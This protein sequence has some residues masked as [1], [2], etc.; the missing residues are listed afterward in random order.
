MIS[1][2]NY[3]TSFIN[4]SEI[5]Y[6]D[7]PEVISLF[8]RHS[9]SVDRINH[10]RQFE[11]AL[12]KKWVTHDCYFRLTSTFIGQAVTDS[13]HLMV[14][15]RLFPLSVRKRFATI[16]GDDRSIPLK[17]YAGTLAAQLLHRADIV[18]EEERMDRRKRTILGSDVLSSDVETESIDDTSSH[19]EDV[20]GITF[21][22]ALGRRFE[23]CTKIRAFTDGNGSNHTIA[24]FPIIQTG[25]A[26]K[27]RA[28]V[29][30]CWECGKETTLFCVECKKPF[31]HSFGSHGHGRK[32]FQDHIPT[33]SCDRLSSSSSSDSS[34]AL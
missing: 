19:E 33:R 32:C 1:I 6:V 16:G 9:N 30:P 3:S 21:V 17:S 20:M 4:E 22:S 26:M 24:K 11:L 10:G 5:R 13:K 18:E 31:C 23:G 8:F 12:K 2:T 14:L 28:R 25:Q 34:T 15:H 29:Q 7:R 27:R